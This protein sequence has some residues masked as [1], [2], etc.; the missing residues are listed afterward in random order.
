MILDDSFDALNVA[1][2]ETSQVDDRPTPSTDD[3]RCGERD[4][5]T[6]TVTVTGTNDGPTVAVDD[7]ATADEDSAVV[8]A[9]DVP[10]PMTTAMLTRAA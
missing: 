10:A 8:T 7:A 3:P 1:L 4:T 2:N 5:A 6:A 9:I